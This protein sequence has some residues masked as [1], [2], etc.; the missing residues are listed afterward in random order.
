MTREKRLMMTRQFRECENVMFTE[1]E[2][3]LQREVEKLK[4]RIM[5]HSLMHRML[6]STLQTE[7][8]SELANMEQRF[9]RRH[10]FQEQDMEMDTSPSRRRDAGQPSTPFAKLRHPMS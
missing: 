4:A 9:A 6:K 10:R 8:D 2:R 3:R 5:L 7:K 1:M